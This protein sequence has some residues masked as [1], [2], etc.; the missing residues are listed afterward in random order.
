MNHIMLKYIDI[1]L[2]DPNPFQPRT[3]F[4]EEAIESLRCSIEKHG[5]LEP[6][7]L[8]E[9][10]SGRYQLI[11]GERRFRAAQKAGLKEAPA[12]IR[13]S[14]D[15]E[16]LEIALIENLH[17]EDMSPVEKALGFKRLLEDFCF[18]QS[19]ISQVMGMSRSAV[20]NTIRLLDLPENI[21]DSINK[22]EITEGH[23]RAILQIKDPEKRELA[24]NRIISRNLTVREAEEL[25]K[26]ISKSCEN[27]ENIK[28][29]RQAE[30]E[31]RLIERLQER[32]GTKV[33]LT[34]A[35]NIGKIEI[36]FYDEE[37]LNRIAEILEID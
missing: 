6:L 25:S 33:H 20:A 15:S 11:A 13:N 17:R 37:D 27:S 19:Q 31:I 29:G 30:Y 4:D 7:I 14:K 18:T 3:F 36:E 26:L 2:I 8:R 23:A 1:N 10:D 12:I 9:A 34:R 21:L 16:M 5:I 32:L 22:K 35:G 28:N 24:L